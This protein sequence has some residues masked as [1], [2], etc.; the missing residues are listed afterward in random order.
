MERGKRGPEL[1][2]E[3]EAGQV[4]LGGAVQKPEGI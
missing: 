3:M 1:E 4:L 2:P